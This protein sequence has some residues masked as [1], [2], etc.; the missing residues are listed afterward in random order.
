MD[1]ADAREKRHK[2]CLPEQG[3][4]LLAAET[5][6]I[7]RARRGEADE[8][9]RKETAGDRRSAMGADLGSG[10]SYAEEDHLPQEDKLVRGEWGCALIRNQRL[11]LVITLERGERL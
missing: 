11:D 10:L 2:W 9:A 8:E 7:A 6:E 5:V 1:R 4:T 3:T